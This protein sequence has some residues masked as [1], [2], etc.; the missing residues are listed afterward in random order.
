MHDFQCPTLLQNVKIICTTSSMSRFHSKL[1]ISNQYHIFFSIV[2]NKVSVPFPISNQFDRFSMVIRLPISWSLVRYLAAQT[3]LRAQKK[4]SLHGQEGN[5]N[6]EATHKCRALGHVSESLLDL[7]V[8]LVGQEVGENRP[9]AILWDWERWQRMD[10]AGGRIH[11][12]YE[13]QVEQ[14]GSAYWWKNCDH[15]ACYIKCLAVL[16]F[17][18]LKM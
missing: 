11:R 6:I 5:H 12:A 9:Q 2:D 3:C 4:N 13:R 10:W 18:Q 8:G 15:G 14:L 1:P 16:V 7:L 17:L